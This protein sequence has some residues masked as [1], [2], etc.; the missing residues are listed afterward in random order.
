MSLTLLP[1]PH[2][3]QRERADCLVACAIMVLAYLGQQPSYQQLYNVLKMR[4]GLGTAMSNIRQ[5]EKLGLSVLYR[6]GTL[7]LLQQH[8]VGNEPCIVP[9]KTSEL[10][11]WQVDT[12]HAVV[13]VGLDASSVYL[14]DPVLP[15]AP[16]YVPRGD[17]ELAWLERDEFFAV[18]QRLG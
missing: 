9:V 15:Y 11:Y 6:Q 8:L 1:V 12:D 2:F 5:L 13:V 4:P 7:P 3:Q 10:P 17:F 16:V 18:V 14:N